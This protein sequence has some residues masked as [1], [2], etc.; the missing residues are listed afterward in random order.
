MI[1]LD[2]ENAEFARLL[3]AVGWTQSHAAE[4]LGLHRGTINQIVNGKQRVSMTSLRL[5]SELTGGVIHLPDRTIGSRSVS[6]GETFYKATG[7][8]HDALHLLRQLPADRR[9]HVLQIARF[10]IPSGSPTRHVAEPT[11]SSHVKSANLADLKS[12][13][14]DDQ[15][16]SSFQTSKDTSKLE[17]E[18][19][20]PSEPYPP[21]EP[22]PSRSVFSNDPAVDVTRS[23]RVPQAP[24]QE[25]TPVVK[26]PP[27]KKPGL[28]LFAGRPALNSKPVKPV[29]PARSVLDLISEGIE[30]RRKQKPSHQ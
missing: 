11:R 15:Q 25:Q 5:L 8:E 12:Q 22:K 7:W 26:S 21:P 10:A 29:N 20:V 30:E 2:P 27:G 1:L 14:V 24:V 16:S 4:Q 28:T 17:P 18:I 9:A 6:V 19:V 3:E 23:S 13:R